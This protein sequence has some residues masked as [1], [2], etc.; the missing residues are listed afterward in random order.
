MVTPIEIFLFVKQLG[1]ALAGAAALWGLVFELKSRHKNQEE[2][3]VI[4]KWIS[5]RLL[6]PLLIGILMAVISWI[7]LTITPLYAHEGITLPL[8]SGQISEALAVMFPFFIGWLIF[9]FIGFLTMMIMPKVFQ[10]YLAP[11]YFI[12][13]LFITLLISIPAWTGEFSRAQ[14]FF[15]GH[16]FHSVLTLGT[17]L[18]LD[19][20]FLTSKH[21][22]ILQQ[23]IFPLTPTLSKV[24]WIGLGIEFISTALIFN[25]A[26]SLTPKFFFMQTIIGI[27]IINGV[28]LSG[29]ITRKILTSIQEGGKALNKKWIS[30]ANIAGVISITS[31]FSITLVD[32]FEN[33]TL[34]Y[35]H[36]ILFYLGLL[37][38]GL[39]GHRIWHYFDRYKYPFN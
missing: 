3:C 30:F 28:L 18:I 15:I 10:K 31:W 7:F 26:I 22:V 11:F 39:L 33:L 8:M 20:L 4:F 5:K 34:N 24:V 25:Q 13:F 27:I 9:S 12:Q 16:G 35:H 14:L 19:F 1:L 38:I 17:V 29:P 32:S 37:I 23:H 6:L 36:F 21:S 2:K